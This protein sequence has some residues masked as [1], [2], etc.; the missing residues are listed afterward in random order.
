MQRVVQVGNCTNACRHR[1]VVSRQTCSLATAASARRPALSRS[2]P[3]I[4]KIPRYSLTRTPRHYLLSAAVD[5][6]TGKT[7]TDTPVSNM[8]RSLLT[9]IMFQHVQELA[10][11][12]VIPN[13]LG[14]TR[15]ATTSFSLC[16]HL[17]AVASKSRR[18]VRR[19]ESPGRGRGVR[20]SRPAAAPKSRTLGG[21]KD[22]VDVRTL[23]KRSEMHPHDFCALRVSRI[24]LLRCRCHF[25]DGS[26]TML[27]VLVWQKKTK[28]VPIAAN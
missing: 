15:A 16:S 28:G 21:G 11:R 7:A 9:D 12:V 19:V 22:N 6:R 1:T 4:P 13:R 3:K 10:E 25:V 8:L 26:C 23:S 20:R 14:V 27:T 2:A 5:S 17:L 18:D 24:H